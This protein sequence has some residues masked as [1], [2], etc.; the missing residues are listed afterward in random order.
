MMTGGL[1][2]KISLILFNTS[3]VNFFATSR[4]PTISSNYSSFEAL[5]IAVETFSYFKTPLIK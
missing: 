2:G 1:K 3:G 4:A 5:V